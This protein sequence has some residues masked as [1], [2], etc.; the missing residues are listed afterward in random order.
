MGEKK[1]LFFIFLLSFSS[2]F[3]LHALGNKPFKNIQIITS[4]FPLQEFASAVVK[5]RGEVSLLLPPGAE[6]HTWRPRAS[7]IIKL[8]SAD[9]VIYVGASLELWLHDI[10]KSAASPK[11]RV[12]EASKGLSLIKEDEDGHSHKEDKKSEEE[13]H[14]HQPK[15]IDPHIWLD[16]EYD[17]II[18]DRI[19]A[20]LSELDPEGETLFRENAKSYKKK[21]QEL[22]KK[23]CEALRNCTHATFI[24]GGH[25]AFG[26]LAKRYDLNQIA[27]YGLSPDSKPTPKQ[28]V[29]VIKVAKENN[30]NAIYFE[31]YV[32]DELAKVIAREIGAETLVLYTGANVTKEQ[33]KSGIT[34]LKIMEKNLESLRHG[35]ICH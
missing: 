17:Q 18:V 15:Y 5:G 27:L 7:D 22:D 19:A 14:G 4:V 2:L 12:L 23:Y 26:Y 11:L 1:I 10:L 6:I 28:L 25:A 13:N 29:D 31:H 32:S 24:L 21:L 16:F 3:S 35:L 30:I 8:Y 20:V 9:L 33:L 34:F